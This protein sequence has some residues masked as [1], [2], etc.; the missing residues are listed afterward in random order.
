MVFQ[1]TVCTVMTMVFHNVYNLLK[2][3]I[4]RNSF[5]YHECIQKWL[6]V[7]L[8]GTS[9][10]CQ[11]AFQHGKA[12]TYFKTS[13]SNK[14]M[15]FLRC[16]FYNTNLTICQGHCCTLEGIVNHFRIIHLLW[17]FRMHITCKQLIPLTDDINRKSVVVS[18]ILSLVKSTIQASSLSP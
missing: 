15:F 18:V 2:W 16:H 5:H 17:W 3:K 14:S 4:N 9:K 13:H 7:S 8:D 10:S 1:P 6:I 11:W 12:K